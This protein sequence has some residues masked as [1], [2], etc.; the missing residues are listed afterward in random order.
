MSQNRFYELDVS[1]AKPI[2][3]Y[4]I[5]LIIDKNQK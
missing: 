5:I 1:D 2:N 3:C 4:N